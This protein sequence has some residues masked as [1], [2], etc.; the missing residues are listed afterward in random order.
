M[1]EVQICSYETSR[2]RSVGARIG[3]IE[4]Q[5]NSKTF[6]LQALISRTC[7]SPSAVEPSHFEFV[8]T[9]DRVLYVKTSLEA[10]YSSQQAHK[11]KRSI[12]RGPNIFPFLSYRKWNVSQHG[13][14][15]EQ[16]LI[17]V[18]LVRSVSQSTRCRDAKSCL[19]SRQNFH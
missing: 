4:G 19:P 17:R 7:F 15:R 8:R 3:S 18:D 5:T 13:Q 9:T 1:T 6:R 16:Q 11:P 12:E 14:K 10:T 2:C